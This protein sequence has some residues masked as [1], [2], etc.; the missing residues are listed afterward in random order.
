MQSP[1]RPLHYP[2]P[3]NIVLTRSGASQSPRT[4]AYSQAKSLHIM[5][6]KEH[7]VHTTL[8]FKAPLLRRRRRCIFADF[9]PSPF[10]ACPAAAWITP[11]A[12]S[13]RWACLPSAPTSP[14]R[15]GLPAWARLQ[16]CPMKP[17]WASLRASQQLTLRGCQLSAASSMSSATTTTSG[18]AC[19]WR[20][21]MLAAAARTSTLSMRMHPRNAVGCSSRFRLLPPLNAASIAGAR[22]GFCVRHHAV[23]STLA[24]LVLLVC[25]GA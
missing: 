15:F 24:L 18:R 17:S 4:P 20:W 3:A 12:C 14:A 8:S 11:T 21:G 22:L 6:C 13:L 1:S 19:A 9:C 2:V 5:H 23:F 16:C 10:A 25:A 7:V